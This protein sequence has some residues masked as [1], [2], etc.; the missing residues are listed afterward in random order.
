MSRP[1][2]LLAWVLL[3]IFGCSSSDS[4]V[5]ERDPQQANEKGEAAL[6]RG[7][8]EAAVEAVRS[9]AEAGLA[10]Y[11][12]SLAVLLDDDQVD[13]LKPQRDAEVL[14]WLRAAAG[15]GHEEAARK[16]AFFHRW[17][18]VGLPKNEDRAVCW[19][20]V[21]DGEA[22]AKECLDGHLEAEERGDPPED[23]SAMI[24]RNAIHPVVGTALQ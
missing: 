17:G 4:G 15:Q 2:P 11:Q 14:K 23:V 21:A 8:I 13:A 7:D 16:L 9:C 18:H 10:E 6:D 24:R 20:R 12:F 1:L 5:D 22:D 19:E 3:L